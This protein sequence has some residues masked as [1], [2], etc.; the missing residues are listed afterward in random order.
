[1][2]RLLF[3]LLLLPLLVVVLAAPLLLLVYVIDVPAV[4]VPV[5]VAARRRREVGKALLSLPSFFVLRT[6]NGFYLLE[7]LW[8][9]VVLRRPLLVYEKGH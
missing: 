9:E 2:S 8:T 3:A 7:A 5:L 1:M 4:L 6:V